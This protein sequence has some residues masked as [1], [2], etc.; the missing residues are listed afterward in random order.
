MP[1]AIVHMHSPHHFTTLLAHP[2]EFWRLNAIVLRFTAIPY[3][4]KPTTQSHSSFIR[5]FHSYSSSSVTVLPLLLPCCPHIN[6]SRST[7]ILTFSSH[8]HFPY[9]K[10]AHTFPLLSNTHAPPPRLLL[11]PTYPTSI[12]IPPII[13]YCTSTPTLCYLS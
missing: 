4:K 6:I 12:L 10:T 13:S 3:W 9:Y 7:L 5:A 2:L 11:L 8:T 1:S